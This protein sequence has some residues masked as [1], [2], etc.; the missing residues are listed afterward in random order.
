[1]KTKT[2]YLY[3]TKAEHLLEK[4]LNK[5]G[6]KNDAKVLNIA[7][8]NDLVPAY[9]KK[10]VDEE[11][12]YGVDIDADVSAANPQIKKC[13]V[14]RESLPFANEAFDLVISVWGLEHFKSDRIFKEVSRVLKSGGYFVALT[15]NDRHP[16]FVASKAFGKKLAPWYYKKILRSSYDPHQTF[17]RLNNVT[18]LRSATDKAGLATKNMFVLGPAYILYYFNFSKILQGLVKFADLLMTVPALG[19]FKPYLLLVAKK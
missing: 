5:L 3:E 13:D 8:E 16:I 7:C 18:D 11:N 1:M 6:L 15:P 10:F 14:D 17:Y 4:E 12:V 19:R 9:L 2:T